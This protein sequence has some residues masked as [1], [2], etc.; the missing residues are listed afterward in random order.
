MTKIAPSLLSANFMNLEKDLISIEKS[1]ADLIH[2]DIMDGHFV[3]NITFGPFIVAQVR[4]LT[5]LPIDA[6]LMIDNPAQFIAPFADAGCDMITVHA[7]T[8]KHL[9]RTLQSIKALGLKAG[10]AINPHSG[11]GFIEAVGDMLDLVLV[12]TVNPG[13]GGQKYIMN[14][15]KK[16]IEISETRKKL[17]LNFE[18][19]VDGGI[20]LATGQKV[21]SYGADILVMGSFFF[22]TPEKERKA[23]VKKAKAL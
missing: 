2:L 10:V 15:G 1:G 6:H 20:N 5:R 4:K 9:H 8:E 7:E 19:S 11:A 3:P 12:M 21:V 23:L 14:A 22:Q 16:I 17:G 18:I 13:F